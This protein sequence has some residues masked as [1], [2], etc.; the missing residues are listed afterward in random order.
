MAGH[1][2][3]YCGLEFNTL[4]AT[5][6]PKA[7]M[8]L[9]QECALAQVVPGIQDNGVLQGMPVYLDATPY[10]LQGYSVDI[11]KPTAKLGITGTTAPVSQKVFFSLAD[12]NAPQP[13][14]MDLNYLVLSG[15]F[16]P[17]LFNHVLGHIESDDSGYFSY[18]LTNIPV[19]ELIIWFTLP[20][21]ESM[22]PSQLEITLDWFDA[23]EPEPD[24]EA[25]D[26]GPKPDEPSPGPE[27]DPEIEYP[28]FDQFEHI[29]AVASY[30]NA[31]DDTSGTISSVL[32]TISGT[33]TGEAT[34]IYLADG[35]L[36]EADINTLKANTF[37]ALA[38]ESN[39]N[40]SVD[41]KTNYGDITCTAWCG[42][43][44]V[45]SK[46][47][48]EIVP[49]EITDCLTGDTL[50]TLAAGG[51]KRFDA[52][53]VREQVLAANNK[54]TTITEISCHIPVPGYMLYTFSNGAQIK[55]THEHRFFN[56]TQGFY[57]RLQSW[58][59]GDEIAA[60]DDSPV[61]LVKREWVE[62]PEYMF[63][64]YTEDGTYWANGLLSGCVENNI[65]ILQQADL[66]L[67]L[68]IA[69]SLY[70]EQY[71]EV[72]GDGLLP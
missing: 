25:P 49:I 22:A 57:Q 27:P 10:Y 12:E 38:V 32:W 43:N 34:T 18:I 68:S 35:D 45:D 36:V 5:Y 14:I 33:W 50:I 31:N 53:Q 60:L 61:Y 59:I 66:D 56:K 15:D 55:E 11:T 6:D 72:F 24:P 2:S 65:P 1:F 63:G 70:S 71:R 30:Y 39:S 13:N 37:L 69:Q 64:L 62:E 3:Y 42:T 9:R 51:Q 17:R 41:Q 7:P 48:I 40:W 44:D 20:A 16:Y 23:P 21:A 8:K 26:P 19:G 52:C 58:N 29:K 67:A 54:V 47:T 46:L 4:L 28:D